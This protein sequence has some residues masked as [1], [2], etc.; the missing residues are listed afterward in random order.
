M[1]VSLRRQVRAEMKGQAVW[2]SSLIG[3]GTITAL[4]PSIEIDPCLSQTS[5]EMTLDW[6]GKVQSRDDIRV[7]HFDAGKISVS[8]R[9]RSFI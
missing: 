4:P 9:R 2:K 6:E 7:G 5:Q 1:T 3:S 8:V